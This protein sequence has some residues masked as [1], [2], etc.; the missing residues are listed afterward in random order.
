MKHFNKLLFVCAAELLTALATAK[1]SEA[2]QARKMIDKVNQ[3]W[4]AENKAEVR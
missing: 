1:T 4:K 2:V 3:Q